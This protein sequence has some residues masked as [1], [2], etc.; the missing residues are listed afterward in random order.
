MREG[1]VAA[2]ALGI[3]SKTCEESRKE[4]R[5]AIRAPPAETFQAVANSR[6][7]LPSWSRL[8]TNTGIASGR[9]A[10]LRRSGSGFRGLKWTS[11]IL[12]WP[13]NYRTLGAKSPGKTGRL[14]VKKRNQRH[15]PGR[16]DEHLPIP[17]P[18][19]GPATVSNIFNLFSSSIFAPLVHPFSRHSSLLI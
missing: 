1:E 9:R 5:T 16:P 10:H 14:P 8:R 6:N 4:R 2:G 3:S 13:F 19:R 18:A 12:G 11:R 7:S 15:F 17:V